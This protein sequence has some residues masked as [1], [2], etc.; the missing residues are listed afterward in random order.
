MRSWTILVT[1]VPA[2]VL[3]AAEALSAESATEQPATP[4]LSMDE[5][6]ALMRQRWQ[7]ELLFKLWKSQGKLASTR[8][9]K[10]Q[11]ILC[12]VYAKVL[13]MIVQHWV[14]VYA[15]WKYADRSLTQASKAV[16]KLALALLHSL[17]DV[18]K[19]KEE[20][21]RIAQM[22]ETTVR[23]HRRKKKPAAFQVMDDPT[24]FGYERCA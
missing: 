21:D 17:S 10:P 1:N 24:L 8:R 18:V 23:I 6:I 16:R 13:A 4:W 14:L 20:L 5:A 19:V 22:A 11:R 7:I 12:E 2:K 3:P 15:A 9:R